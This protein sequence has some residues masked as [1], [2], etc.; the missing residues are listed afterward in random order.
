GDVVGSVYEGH[1]VKRKDFILL[2]M[3]SHPTDDSMMTIAVSKAMLENLE[4][5]RNKEEGYQEALYDSVVQKMLY[6]GN[7]YIHKG[8]GGRFR[9]WLKSSTHEPY[10]S[11]GN[12]SAMRVSP[13]GWVC[14]NL[15]DTLEIA[16][17]TALPTH[18]H[19]EGIKGAQSVAAAIFLL[20]TGHDKEYIKNYISENFE[21]D[22]DRTLDIIRPNYRFEVSC[23]KSVPEAFIA[24]LEG[25]SYEEVIRGA[26]SI[27]GDSD[28]IAAIAG[29]M[30]EVIYP[31]EDK[32]I[33][34]IKDHL[35]QFTELWDDRLDFYNK[36]VIPYKIE[37]GLAEK[38]LD[39]TVAQSL[40]Q[41]LL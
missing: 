4:K 37:K 12:G 32:F 36:I 17:I 1:N 31:I 33:T 24:F 41:G 21:Y 35:P 11:Y 2:R 27:G 26:I 16:K 3:E 5:I 28:T 40:R 14:D 13:A 7:K 30:A 22:L 34:Y 38:E 8:Y 15:E 29:S 6:Y 25:E 39:M 23:Q 18:N 9:A 19:P 20:R 10:N